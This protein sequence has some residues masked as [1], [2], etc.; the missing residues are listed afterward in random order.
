ME[1]VD[2]LWVGRLFG[3]V[4]LQEIRAGAELTHAHVEWVAT[5]DGVSEA[6]EQ[7]LSAAHVRF[8]AKRGA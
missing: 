8:E 6:L 7:V 2:D 1:V 3:D 4:H 5:R